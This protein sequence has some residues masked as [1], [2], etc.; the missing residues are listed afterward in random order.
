MVLV[1]IDGDGEIGGKGE[2]KRD[3]FNQR[4]QQIYME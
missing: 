2:R 4:K 1:A 3:T